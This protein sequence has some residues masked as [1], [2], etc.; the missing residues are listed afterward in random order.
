MWL[1]FDHFRSACIPVTSGLCM[2]RVK[3]DGTV[4]VGTV[5]GR[6]NL[7]EL[8]LGRRRFVGLPGALRPFDKNSILW[9]TA[10]MLDYANKTASY[11]N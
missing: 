8:L 6:S 11:V 4:M 5:M 3:L 2:I 1:L 10:K 7:A 9:C